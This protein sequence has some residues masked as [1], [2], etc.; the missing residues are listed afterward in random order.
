M[1]I[2]KWDHDAFVAQVKKFHGHVA[3]GV[4]IGGYMVEMA[5]RTLPEGILY[6]AISETVQC[7]PDAIQLLT[8]CT[9]GNGWL[10]VYHFGIYALTLYNK[11]T[12]EGTRVRLNVDALQAYPH[13]RAWVFKEK[14]KREQDPEL[15]QAEIKAAGM[16]LLQ[17]FPAR[18]HA[19]F[20]VRRGKGAVCRCPKC[21]EWYP[22]VLGE[23]CRIC[24]GDGPYERHAD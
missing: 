16:Q 10:R 12:G 18:I 20:L 13:V 24:Q 15:L 8:P 9:V 4:I 5:R 17:A 1:R 2:G 23:V 6:D 7:L 21:G 14:P 22:A 19:D 11:Q 3:P